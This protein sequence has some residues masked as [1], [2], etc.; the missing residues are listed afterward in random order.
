MSLA[1]RTARLSRVSVGPGERDSP[2]SSSTDSRS[3]AVALRMRGSLT[4][5]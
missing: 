5:S 3:L 4:E 2:H 1:S